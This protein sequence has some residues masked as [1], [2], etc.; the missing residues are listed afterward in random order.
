MACANWLAASTT[1]SLPVPL[2]LLALIRPKNAMSMLRSESSS[3]L[4]SVRWEATDFFGSVLPYASSAYWASFC[5]CCSPKNWSALV[6]PGRFLSEGRPAAFISSPVAFSRRSSS[7]S[8]SRRWAIILVNS[9]LREPSLPVSRVSRKLSRMAFFHA[10]ELTR[11]RGT[12][13]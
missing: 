2:S 6:L 7:G 3:F 4:M 9:R 8:R 1:Y 5:H 12:P 13:P 11:I 10:C